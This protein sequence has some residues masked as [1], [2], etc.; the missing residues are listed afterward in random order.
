MGHTVEGVLSLDDVDLSGRTVLYR[1][2]V[3][4]PLEPA[5]GRILDDGRL[6]AILPTLQRLSK[7]KVVVLSHQ[8]RPGKSD[9]T[10]TEAHCR[11]LQE[12][13]GREIEFVED[14]CGEKA[15]QAIES[16]A[17]GEVIFLDNVRTN[18]EE[19]GKKY[20]SNEDT[21]SS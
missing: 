9:F 10:N 6:R 2:D 14:I 20:D 12:I 5:S 11:I 18:E 1:V 19:Y 13:S 17:N 16:M 3:N 21:E 8:S 4:S 15:I 7:S